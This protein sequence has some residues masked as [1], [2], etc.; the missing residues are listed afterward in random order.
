MPESQPTVAVLGTMTVC[1]ASTGSIPQDP[2]SVDSELEQASV[3]AVTVIARKCP[4]RCT[5]PFGSGAATR[6]DASPPMIAIGAE[7]SGTSTSSAS[8]AITSGITVIAKGPYVGRESPADGWQI[9][10]PAD[11]VQVSGYVV[12]QMPPDLAG[13]V[14]GPTSLT[15]SASAGVSV[16]EVGSPTWRGSGVL[17]LPSVTVMP[18]MPAMIPNS[19]V[20]EN[21]FPQLTTNDPGWAS[22]P[23]LRMNEV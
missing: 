13:R 6:V 16:I 2:R 20:F 5:S 14:I 3:A 8:S 11:L 15:P 12:T 10:S 23:I 9:S 21:A 18:V 4:A 17:P 22:S 19:T 1:A 7:P